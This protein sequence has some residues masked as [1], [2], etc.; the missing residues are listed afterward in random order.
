MIRSESDTTAPRERD[1][2]RPA[3]LLVVDCPAQRATTAAADRSEVDSTTDALIAA[4][5]ARAGQPV[6]LHTVRHVLSIPR[7]VGNTPRDEHGDHS[8]AA[9]AEVAT[10][11]EPKFRI[12]LFGDVKFSAIDSTRARNGFALGQFDLFGQSQ[13][14]DRLSVLTEATLTALP[15]N[16]F[17]ARL[18]RLLVTYW[19][20]DRF[21]ASAGRYHSS[22]GYYNTA[23]HHGSWFQTAVGRPIVFALDG[24][25]GLLPTHTLGVATTGD[26]PSGGL[27]L[28]YVAELGSGRAGQSS[29]AT[30]PQPA[31]AD[32]NTPSLNVALI[33]R[34]ER[35]DGLQMGVSLYRDRLTLQDTSKA[36]ID[37]MVGARAR[38]VQDG[39]GRAARGVARDPSPPAR[40]RGVEHVARVVRAGVPPVRRAAPVRALRLRGR[41]TSQPG[42]RL[43]RPPQRTDG[44]RALGL[45]R[46][47]RPQAAG[48][49]SAADDACDPESG[50]RASVV[51]VLMRSPKMPP[52]RWSLAALVVSLLGIAPRTAHAQESEPLAIV[53]NRSNPLTE[54]SLADLRRVYRGQ[55]S[56]WSNGRRVTL[57]MRDTGTAE[58]DAILQSLY[59][60]AEVEYRRTYL[61]AIF[62]GQASDAPKTLASTNGVL[63][64]VYNVPGAIGYVRARDVD[65]S[66]KML[67]IDGRLPGEP[68]Y[69]LEVSA[70]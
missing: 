38:A 54:I 1:S 9:E 69:R 18:E 63:R 33:T 31:L 44:R 17:N 32:N 53:V 62:S 4:L 23:Y 39:R 55:R 58:R 57:V 14:S 19:A 64:F 61:Q 56:R 60:V 15:R 22:I 66:V 47:G 29:A 13:L 67:R 25:I 20:S 49:P 7:D 21:I 8:D 24:D 59:G 11:A 6:S 34:P 26:I 10:A 16:T 37:E 40:R 2:S 45:R 51:H 46:A 42:V 3:R 50:R 12:H 52:L 30:A 36:P 70:Q 43:P 5:C 28:R 65:P 35:W 48:Q 68:G 27:G 41:P